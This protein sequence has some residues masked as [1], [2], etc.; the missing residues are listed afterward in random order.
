MIIR[1][2]ASPVANFYILENRIAED[3]RLS[4]E[5][6]GV[7][8]F[9]LVKPTDWT[10]RVSHLIDSGPAGKDKIARII[11]E[12]RDAG[13]ISYCRRRNGDGTLGESEYAV[14]EYPTPDDPEEPKPE[15]P[16]QDGKPK[17]EKPAVDAETPKP[18]NPVVDAETP[19]PENPVVDAETP[20]PEKPVQDGEP[21][22]EKPA[23]DKPALDNPPL[24]STHLNQE[25]ILTKNPV[26]QSSSSKT[27]RNGVIMNFA[28]QPS[29]E[30]LDLI[31]HSGVPAEF[32]KAL[33]PEFQTYWML[34]SEKP[35]SGNWNTSFHQHCNKA[36]AKSQNDMGRMKNEPKWDV[37]DFDWSSWSGSGEYDPLFVEHW[38][39]V[40]RDARKVVTQALVDETAIE[41]ASVALFF[42]LHFGLVVKEAAL[43]GW[44]NI[45]SQHLIEHMHRLGYQS[46]PNASGLS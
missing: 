14:H 32:S 21:K 34:S 17:P 44:L 46:S 28:W 41:V 11:K 39:L 5:A 45:R 15:K 9:L 2:S 22:P 12:L 30:T 7:L 31:R 3:S 43:T 8:I 38:L 16:V 6:R 19:K 24:L 29:R 20:K 42:N 35:K 26:N 33:V 25:P 27:D 18:E 1:R 13:Y 37:D 10:V 36:W 4:W 40:R 23:L